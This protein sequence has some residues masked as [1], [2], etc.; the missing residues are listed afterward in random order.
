MRL[1]KIKLA[2]F[3]SFVDPTTIRFPSNLCGVVGPNGCGKSNIIDAVRWVMGESSAKHLRGDS[4][5]DVIFNGA[6]ARKPVGQASIEL[7]FDNSDGAVGGQ[8]A[9]FNEI[10]VRRQVSR[11]G[12]SVYF[13]NG[14][15]CRRRDITDIFLG[16]GLG[17]RSYAIIEQ[18]MISRLIEARPEELRVLMEEAAGI[19]KYKERRRETENRIRHTREN[20]E[21]LDD[22]REELDKQLGHLQRQ[23]RTAERFKELRARERRARAELTAL[24][25]RDC[26]RR[27]AALDSELAERGNRHEQALAEQ[28]SAESGIEQLREQGHEAG[29]TFRQVQERYYSIG[30]DIAR[31]EQAIQ[32]RR[33]LRQRQARELE[34]V[35][36][37]HGEV[38]ARL[39][40]DREELEAG[41][42]ELAELT[43]ALERL[44]QAEGEAAQAMQSAE[45]VLREWQSEREAHAVEAA[46]CRRR[47][48]V[49]QARI[50]QLEHR[51]SELLQRR[52]RLRDQARGIDDSSAETES[53][54]LEQRLGELRDSYSERERTLEETR[55][56]VAGLREEDQRLER[57]LAEARGGHQA[58]GGRLESL[59]ALQQAALEDRDEA[60]AGWL[61]R[62]GLADR[63]R[64]AQAIRVTGGWERAVE[65]VLGP[66][67]EAV[68]TE[69]LEQALE[70]CADLEQGSLALVAAAD[71]G[72]DAT[73]AD[74]SLSRHVHGPV[75]ARSLLTGVVAVEDVPAAAA[76]RRHL[77]DGQSVVTRDGVWLG[78]D[79]IRVARGGDDRAGVIGR[80]RE[81]ETLEGELDRA[82]ARVRSLE[83]GREALRER[84]A[85]TER[86]RDELQQQVNEL[87]RGISD[88]AARWDG[89]R[90]RME[91]ARRRREALREELETT[92]GAIAELEDATREARGRLERAMEELPALE[93]RGGKLQ[94]RGRD[95]QQALERARGNHREQRDARHALEL[96]LESRRS[97]EQSTSRHLETLE[98]QL[99][100]LERRRAELAEGLDDTSGPGNEEREQ[101]DA[102][103]QRRVEVEQDLSRRRERME[104]LDAELREAERRRQAQEQRVAALREELEQVRTRRGEIR[105]RQQSLADQMREAGDDPAAVAGELSEDATA[106]AREGDLERLSGQ[107][108]R[109]GPINLAAIEEFETQ[110]E[111]KEY[112]DRQHADLM[113][114][115]ETLENAIRRIDRETRARFRET[116]DRVNQG[117]Q[118]M[119]PRL[120]GGGHAYLDLTGEDLLDTGVTIMAR[121]PGKRNSTIHLLSGGEKALTAVALVFAIFELNPAPFCMLDEV[122]APLDDANVG[123]FCELVRDMSE[124]VQF[125]MVTHNKNTM[126]LADQLM[127]VTMHEPGVSRLVSVDVDGAVE[128]AAM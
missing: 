2:G 28:R 67:L 64:L 127:G 29:E 123:R 50:Q 25:W 86:G 71:G 40:R 105:G 39:R 43:P 17:P 88:I 117:V 102:L 38:E 106:D 114:A 6:S 99:A 1:S 47:V 65:T 14:T 78:R 124:R 19:S 80:Q 24:R 72:E 83:Q 58:S 61:D 81:I 92:Q 30:A 16:T 10:S 96:K 115:L 7:V 91:Q 128:L 37:S 4:M 70:G 27:V 121:P 31:L 122:D 15:R 75:A 85:E 54:A 73:A 98:E 119:F 113:D 26:E 49:E 62:Q 9:A 57:E 74:D 118:A 112:L 42:A 95:A 82:G 109:L 100:G 87:H 36:H 12:S 93:E 126:E 76:R 5:A 8:Y 32:H 111:R 20:I 60:V 23:A 33:E 18:G 35:E 107:I 89:E 22:L 51:M 45:E 79:W 116:F 21:R 94:A 59:R 90:Q 84:I 103:L 52:D 46:E 110:S 34:Q 120:F 48:E 53:E 104:A 41:R 56:A 97:T 44:Q 101:L 125:I 11:D 13:L 63:P 69:N 3:K 68:C 55:S 108:E 66:C 77:Q